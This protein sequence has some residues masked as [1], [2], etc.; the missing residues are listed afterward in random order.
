VQ[1]AKTNVGWYGGAGF[2]F[3]FGRSALFLESRYINVN[4]QKPTGFPYDKANYLPVILG[5]QF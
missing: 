1:N 4:A 5:L 2:N 3:R